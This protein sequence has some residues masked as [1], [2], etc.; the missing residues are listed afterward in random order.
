LHIDFETLASSVRDAVQ[1]RTGV[2]HAA[3]TASTGINSE[4]A[5]ILETDSGRV[6]LKGLP[7]NHSGLA[8]QQREASVN[9]HLHDAGPRLLWHEAVEGWDLLAFE[10]VEDAHHVEYGPGSPDLPK[11]VALLNELG[12]IRRPPVPL[13]AAERRWASY[14]DNEEDAK[15]FAGDN[16]LHTDFNPSNI[17]ITDTR[18]WMVD[19]AW[20]TRGA[21]F[22]DPACAVPRLITAGHTPAMAES[23]A[24]QTTSWKR[25]D[26]TSVDLFAGAIARALRRF[27]ENDPDG[28]WRRPMVEAAESWARHRAQLAT[29]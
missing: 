12:K 6:F 11:L 1:V 26:P 27:A 8:G 4:I 23:W 24:A 13:M 21:G 17:L 18:A 19:W 16:L 2:V 10:V 22:I 7:Q 15:H 20:A 25:A 29:S 3:Q 14:L 5:A 9:P 28:E